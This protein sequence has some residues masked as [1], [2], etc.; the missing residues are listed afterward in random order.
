MARGAWRTFATSE[1]TVSI[2]TYWQNGLIYYNLIPASFYWH[3]KLLP[4]QIIDDHLTLVS[5]KN[6]I[7]ANSLQNHP[8]SIDCSIFFAMAQATSDSLLQAANEMCK[9]GDF[10]E[11]QSLLDQWSLAIPYKPLYVGDNPPPYQR[12]LY[13]A[14]SCDYICLVGFLL[15]KGAEVDDEA[16]NVANASGSLEVF[17]KFLDHGWDVNSHPENTS[18]KYDPLNNIGMSIC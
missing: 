18:L 9:A 15:E 2:P 8:F 5:K 10:Q 3:F 16:R 17:Q 1:H 11:T 14:I 7:I 13:R 4:H 12:Q 6:T